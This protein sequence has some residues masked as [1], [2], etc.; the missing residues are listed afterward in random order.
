MGRGG[1]G[2][3]P[4]P[5]CGCCSQ[6][7]EQPTGAPWRVDGAL[8]AGG[9]LAAADEPPAIAFHTDRAGGGPLV[10]GLRLKAQQVGEI[11]AGDHIAGAV[12]VVL[13]CLRR[14]RRGG[15]GRGRPRRSR[16][17]C[18]GD[19]NRRGGENQLAVLGYQ[20][21]EEAF[22]GEARRSERPQGPQYGRLG[23]QP[24]EDAQKLPHAAPK[25]RSKQ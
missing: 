19:A 10:D 23:L 15:G 24:Q 7:L 13:W 21:L 22:R 17:R 9:E 16:H 1:P 12:A 25:R 8:L 4:G 20:P 18:H 3:E 2:A 14:R 5:W 11:G 6:L